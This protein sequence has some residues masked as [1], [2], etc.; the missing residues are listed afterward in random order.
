MSGKIVIGSIAEIEDERGERMEVEISSAGGA[1]AVSPD[2][3]LGRALLGAGEGKS[4]KVAAPRG[5]WRARILSV[6]R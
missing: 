1:D 4:V 3:P 5:A 2:S 6:R